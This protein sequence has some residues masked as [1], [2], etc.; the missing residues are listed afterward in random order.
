[1]SN[2]AWAAVVAVLAIVIIVLAWFLFASPA[3][4]PVVSP[5]AT[6]TTET[7]QPKPAPTS[8]ANPSGPLDTQVSV[9]APLPNAI[10]SHTFDITGTA[11]NLW[12]DE[13]V[14]PI[15]VRDANDDLVGTAQGEAQSDWTVSGPVAFKSQITVDASYEGPANLILLRDNPSGLP[16]NIDSVTIPIVVQ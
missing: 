13:A 14:F 7:T 16:Q 6:T 2:R 8:N 4:A 15:Q 9:T 3:A 1:M 5:Q 12:Y 11:P 10:V